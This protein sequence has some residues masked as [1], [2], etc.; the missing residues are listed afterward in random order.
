MMSDKQVEKM[1]EETVVSILKLPKTEA[2]LTTEELKGH[3]T[4]IYIKDSFE[5]LYHALQSESSSYE[6][7]SIPTYLS[8]TGQNFGD[9]SK[10][11]VPL[12]AIREA[13]VSDVE[14]NFKE[15]KDYIP[16]GATA[17]FISNLIVRR[18]IMPE[19]EQVSSDLITKGLFVAYDDKVVIDDSRMSSITLSDPE[20]TLYMALNEIKT[21]N[22]FIKELNKMKKEVQELKYVSENDKT[23]F[24]E[25]ATQQLSY[26]NARLVFAKFDSLLQKNEA[27]EV[28]E[29]TRISEMPALQ[30]TIEEAEKFLE[31]ESDF[32]DRDQF[33]TFLNET[34]EWLNVA[35]GDTS[36]TGFAQKNIKLK[37]RIKY[38]K[39]CIAKAKEEEE[40]L[41]AAL[42]TKI[43]EEAKEEKG[44]SEGEVVDSQ[45]DTPSDKVDGQCDAEDFIQNDNTEPVSVN[46][47]SNEAE[48]K[49]N[50]SDDFRELN[51]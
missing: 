32:K 43:Q 21:V 49:Q 9:Y 44:T 15:V 50:L 5:E 3:K 4:Y 14:K 36:A 20:I 42:E 6:F 16:E 45:K 28:L 19:I 12:N 13:L 18:K 40:K 23:E 22:R 34:K 26:T 38:A 10:V 39:T 7:L 24:L 37:A 47:A 46:D 51:L 25:A 33:V 27:S 31:T 41:K 8:E 1:T 17:A 29:A 35:I 48:N 30:K 2:V 11:E